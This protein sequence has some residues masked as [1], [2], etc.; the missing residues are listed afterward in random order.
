MN[1]EP[2]HLR[3]L[4]EIDDS[5]DDKIIL[6]RTKA[7]PLPGEVVGDREQVQN[8]IMED[9]PGWLDLVE[10]FD[11]KKFIN[12]K[13]GRLICFKNLE[14]LQML[15][16][17]SLEGK[18]LELLDRSFLRTVDNWTGT[19]AQVEEILTRNSAEN[20]HAAKRLLSWPGACGTYLSK[21]ASRRDGIVEKGPL[22]K[23]TRIQQ[24]I[25]N[26]N[27]NEGGEECEETF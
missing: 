13:T 14:L 16:V 27:K 25:L 26:L 3:V 9:L 6:L 21:L 8:K 7:S 5:M 12:S 19:A 24:Y 10:K 4:P 11:S 20:A 1:C 2:H 22:T 18:L 15:E 23:K 17:V